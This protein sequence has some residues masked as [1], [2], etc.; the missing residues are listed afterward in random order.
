MPATVRS[1]VPGDAIADVGGGSVQGDEGEV[2]AGLDECVAVAG[3]IEARGVGLQLD[4]GNAAFL[5]AADVLG[6]ARIE[7]G[8]APG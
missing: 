4:L 2:E 6:Q 7:R 8:L 1:K 5:A 3:G